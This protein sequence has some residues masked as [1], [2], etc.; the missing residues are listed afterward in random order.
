[1]EGDAAEFADDDRLSPVMVALG[2]GVFPVVEG[3]L[4]RHDLFLVRIPLG[5]FRT[6]L[7]IVVKGKN[8]GHRMLPA[9]IGNNRAV[10]I[11]G[12][13]QMVDAL[14]KFLLPH[15]MENVHDSP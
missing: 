8:V 4:V 12:L 1:M 6:C 11:D 15:I 10:G 9:V 3:G 2:E 7:H 13:G 5:E 14:G